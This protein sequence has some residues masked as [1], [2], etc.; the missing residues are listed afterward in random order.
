MSFGG[1]Q[2]GVGVLAVVSRVSV[3]R[4]ESPDPTPQTETEYEM[5]TT[6]SGE[7][8]EEMP[9]LR[10]VLT[11]SHALLEGFVEKAQAA[12]DDRD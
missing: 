11:I 6:E 8:W 7:V 12:L 5:K 2:G 1:T 4:C 10:H 3:H 9:N